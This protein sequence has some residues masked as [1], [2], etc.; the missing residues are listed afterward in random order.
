M[1]NGSGGDTSINI[2]PDP[3]AG[4]EVS[5]RQD[6][7]RKH[8]ADISQRT[9]AQ[10]FRSP[11]PTPEGSASSAE[12]LQFVNFLNTAE[13]NT[14]SRNTVRVQARRHAWK[15]QKDEEAASGRPRQPKATRQRS[16]KP[17][18]AAVIKLEKKAPFTP[19]SSSSLRG[20]SASKS[21]RLDDL[22]HNASEWEPSSR[23][24]TS[25]VPTTTQPTFK[26]RRTVTRTDDASCASTSSREEKLG[27][28]YR[29]MLAELPADIARHSVM[30]LAMTGRPSLGSLRIENAHSDPFDSYP[31]QLTPKMHHLMRYC[32]LLLFLEP[33]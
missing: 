5:S 25:T 13:R 24:N 15:E 21:V 9:V 23:H 4:D 6:T 29:A 22:I 7:S 2:K 27:A 19:G 10:T 20:I 31:I 16:R 14:Q 33:S 18:A 26:K 12:G 1:D 28:T 11:V 32:R 3:D 17:P 30:A 8:L